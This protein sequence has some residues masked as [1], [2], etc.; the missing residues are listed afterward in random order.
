MENLTAFVREQTLRLRAEAERSSK[1]FEQRVAERA[2]FLWENVGRPEGRGQ[3]F[4]AKAVEVENLRKPSWTDI[5]AVLTVIKRRSEENRKSE[6]D[7]RNDWCLNLRGADLRVADFE[8]AHLERAKLGSANLQGIDFD[9]AHLEQVE[10]WEANLEHAHLHKADLRQA[11][12]WRANL[13]RAWLVDA[14]LEKTVL[15]DVNLENATLCGAHLQ[16]ADFGGPRFDPPDLEGAHLEGADLSLAKGVTQAQIDHTFGD[17]STKLPEGVTR[18]ARW[19][20]SMPTPTQGRP[21]RR[22]EP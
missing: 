11:N 2:Y 6:R 20:G 17:A 19:L 10:L 4:W 15:W 5:A 12:L 3:E 7:P 21:S 13:K 9:N 14:H 18:P 16:E 1:P 8:G 22:R